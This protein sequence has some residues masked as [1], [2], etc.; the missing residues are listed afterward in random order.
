MNG[1]EVYYDRLD[2]IKQAVERY[3]TIEDVFY[4]AGTLTFLITDKEIKERFKRLYRDLKKLGFIPAARKQD[5][6][7]VIRVFRYREP[8]F[9]PLKMKNLPLILFL[10]TFVIVAADGFLR[11]SS[12]AYEIFYGKTA[13]IDKLAE[14]IFF[15][16]ALIMII[17]LHEL[18]H[19]I[20]A[21]KGGMEATL[22]YFIP[23]IPGIMPTFGAVIFQKEPIVNRDEMFDL[24]ISGPVMSF[25]ISLLIALFAIRTSVIW[26]TPDEYQKAIETIRSMHGV[27][28]PTP[29]ILDLL[30]YL[31]RVPG[32]LP[33]VSGAV[34]F[35]VWLGFFITA[36]NLFPIW[37]LD[38]SKIFRSLL[39]AKQHR[40]AN[41]VSLAIL[42]LAGHVLIALL[43]F[44]LMSRTPDIPPLDEVSPLSRGRKLAFIGVFLMIALS[45][46]P[47]IYS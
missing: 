1:L 30:I 10:V 43:F 12:P 7:I 15:T 46:V 5:G 35:A 42:A 8:V 47:A 24:G 3:F 14:A 28:L 2:E 31:F 26:M 16:V 39:T 17:G 32:K 41:Y 21:K 20:A 44:F 29:L 19:L 11:A 33:F 22:P 37:Q 27:F 13:F 40:I 9:K 25:V 18:G 4:E 45:F 6:K 34:M 23:G 36:L 38:G